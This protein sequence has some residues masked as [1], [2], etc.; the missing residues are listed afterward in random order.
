MRNVLKVVRPGLM[1]TV[2]DLGRQGY[3]Q[4]GM[5]VSG[6]MDPYALRVANLLVGNQQEEAG[7]EITMMGP[8]LEILDDTV[9]AICGA[10]LSPTLEGVPI[11]AWKSFRVK[12]GQKIR[13]GAPKKGARAYLTV[14]GGFDVPVVMGSKSTY[15]KAAI[16]GVE[17]RPL[18]KR[19]VLSR[20]ESHVSLEKWVGRRLHPAYI[21]DYPAH[22]KARV[23][24]GPDQDAFTESGIQTFLNETYEITTQAD[25]MGYRLTGPKIQHVTGADILSDAIAPGT[26]QVPSGGEP[27][28]LLADRQ[29]IGGYTR[30]GTVIT[31]DIPFIAQMVPGNTIAFE[32]VTVEEAQRLFVEQEMFLKGLKI[33][34]GV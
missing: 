15:M 34:A 14:A 8:E 11:P 24:L 20:G 17:G 16:G 4:Y 23:V 12:K 28:I 5:V 30:I 22:F 13:F 31:V 1:T 7:L 10:D 25:R 33:E 19:D 32:S 6:A 29:T 3:Q 27:I 2:Q 18:Q 26:I 21:P 9:M